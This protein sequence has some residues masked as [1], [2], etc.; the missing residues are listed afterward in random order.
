MR[1]PKRLRKADQHPRTRNCS[2]IPCAS[3]K[4]DET[5]TLQFAGLA[6]YFIAVLAPTT[7]SSTAEAP[8][9]PCSID[10]EA[11]RKS[12]GCAKKMFLT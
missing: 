7:G 2:L 11:L 9:A 4:C 3:P 6:I 10:T 8:A 12:E 5:S 1:S